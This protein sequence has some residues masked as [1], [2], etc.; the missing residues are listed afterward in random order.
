MLC[1][2]YLPCSPFFTFFSPLSALRRC[3]FTISPNPHLIYSFSIL[4]NRYVSANHGSHFSELISVQEGDVVTGSNILD[5]KS[6]VWNIT[7]SAPGRK[8]SVLSFKPVPGAWPTA[9]HVLEAY[10][11]TNTCNLYPSAGSVNF[12]NV[13]VSFDSKPVMPI[14]WQFDTQTAGC[15]EHTTADTQGDQVSIHFNTN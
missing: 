14:K 9:Y 1:F 13:K 15:G 2:Y 7:C 5:A 6:G 4:Y 10:G 12:T 8:S 3:S 11:V